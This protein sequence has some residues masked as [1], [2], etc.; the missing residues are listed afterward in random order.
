ME[1]DSFF[2]GEAVN[3]SLSPSLKKQQYILFIACTFL[4]VSTRGHAKNIHYK[5]LPR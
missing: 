2:K 1:L 3:L 4:A 5:G